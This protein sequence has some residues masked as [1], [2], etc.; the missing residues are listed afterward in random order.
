MKFFASVVLCCSF[1]NASF[2]DGVY[3]SHDSNIVISDV[4][5]DGEVLFDSVT[6]NLDFASGQFSVI[7]T[8]EKSTTTAGTLPHTFQ[9]EHGYSVGFLGCARTGEIHNFS[10]GDSRVVICQIQI[11]NHRADM[12]IRVKRANAVD[13]F[14]AKEGSFEIEADGNTTS[15][16]NSYLEVFLAKEKPV[17][18]NYEFWMSINSSSISSFSI[19]ILD[20]NFKTIDQIEFTDIGNF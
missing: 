16:F 18:V 1:I 11:T 8:K 5:V 10:S 2:A 17:T 15:S 20:V 12:P 13:N 7:D 19:D 3:T 14:S 6:L 4:S 9:S